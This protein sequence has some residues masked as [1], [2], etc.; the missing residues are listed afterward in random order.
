MT[1]QTQDQPMVVFVRLFPSREEERKFAAT[2]TAKNIRAVAVCFSGGGDSGSVEDIEYFLNG[3]E[4]PHRDA[5]F[6]Y[7]RR[8]DE[9][10]DSLV[11]CPEFARIEYYNEGYSKL[12]TPEGLAPLSSVVEALFNVAHPLTGQ[13]WYNNDGGSGSFTIT[14]NAD[15]GLD[16]YCDM[17]IYYQS[18]DEFRYSMAWPLPPDSEA[19]DDGKEE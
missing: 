17:S 11:P 10:G 13:D 6:R 14:V 19:A 8:D 15:G 18:S 1:E 7:P 3:Q 16:I 12:F 4:R 2:L 5:R 9:L